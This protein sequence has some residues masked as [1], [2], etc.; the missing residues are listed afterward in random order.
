MPNVTPILEQ[1]ARAYDPLAFEEPKF[2][3]RGLES[4]G[5]DC[6]GR[7]YKARRSTAIAKAKRTIQALIDC[8]WPKEVHDGVAFIDVKDISEDPE[9]SAKVMLREILRD[10]N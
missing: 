2:P 1:V 8:D 5:G 6:M 10:T 9:E 7:L 4:D 3:P